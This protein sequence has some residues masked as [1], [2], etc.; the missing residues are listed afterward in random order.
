M[1]SLILSFLII[2]WLLYGRLT[3]KVFSP[4]D[5]QTPA[6]RI[7]DGVDCIPFSASCF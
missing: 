1:I 5:R 7:N 2:G 4:D 3:E 6:V